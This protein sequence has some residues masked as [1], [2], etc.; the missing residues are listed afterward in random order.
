MASLLFG[1]IEGFHFRMQA[2]GK[3]IPTYFL[4]MIAYISTVLALWIV[5]WQEG[6]DKK[7]MALRD[8]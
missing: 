2:F 4:R 8:T 1:G 5:T 6:V 7:G 3:E